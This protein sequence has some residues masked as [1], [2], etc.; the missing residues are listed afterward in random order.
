MN[1]YTVSHFTTIFL[2]SS[3]VTFFVFFLFVTSTI[4]LRVKYI[5]SFTEHV[6]K[7]KEREEKRKREKK[8]L[9]SQVSTYLILVNTSFT[10]QDLDT[11]R[12]SLLRFF[13]CNSSSKVKRREKTKDIFTK[14]SCLIF[15][16]EFWMD[17]DPLFLLITWQPKEIVLWKKW[18]LIYIHIFTHII[19]ITRLWWT[20]RN[21]TIPMLILTLIT[22]QFF[23]S[24]LTFAW[25]QSRRQL[26]WLL[27][28]SLSFSSCQQ[29]FFSPIMLFDKLLK[30]KLHFPCFMVVH[31][32]IV[33]SAMKG[34]RWGEREDCIRKVLQSRI[35]LTR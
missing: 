20:L 24:R 19:L 31:F 27:S 18:I 17:F 29:S 28:L 1:E 23:S 32:G 30:F 34:A 33:L 3:P 9:L 22:G 13:E 21:I 15:K 5:P 10:L 25:G 7:R 26:V 6:K 8:K 14:T 12:L 4:I 11:L 35:P 16:L 2:S